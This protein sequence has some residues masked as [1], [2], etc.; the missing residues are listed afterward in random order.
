MFLLLDPGDEAFMIL[1]N[2]IYT[3]SSKIRQCVLLYEVA[4]QAEVDC[5]FRVF[6]VGFP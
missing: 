2:L 4:Y 3:M 6:Y 1:L 5:S